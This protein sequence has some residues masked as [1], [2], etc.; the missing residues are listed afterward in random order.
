MLAVGAQIP[1]LVAHAAC[2]K[3]YFLL[4]EIDAERRRFDC[5]LELGCLRTSDGGDS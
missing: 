2:R 1:S 5:R 4:A 3:G